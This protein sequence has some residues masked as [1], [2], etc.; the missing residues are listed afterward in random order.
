GDVPEA[1]SGRHVRSGQ[2]IGGDPNGDVGQTG[3]RRANADLQSNTAI[4]RIAIEGDARGALPRP[5]HRSPPARKSA[6]RRCVLH[7]SLGPERIEAAS[8]LE[9]R[10]LPDIALEYFAIVADQLDDAID[11]ILGQSELLAEISFRAE[12]PLYFR[13]IGFHLLIKV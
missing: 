12:H 2:I 11:P 9:R 1:E 8:D 13:I 10:A 6:D 5:Y 7:A 4:F 3:K